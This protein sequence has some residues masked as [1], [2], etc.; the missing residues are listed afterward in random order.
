MAGEIRLRPLELRDVDELVEATGDEPTSFAPGGEEGR[1]RLRRQIERAPT[2][3]D[4]GFF[5]LAVEADG[6][7]CGDVQARSPV[8][9][10]PPGV[11]EIGITLF[12]DARGRGVGREAVRLFT[13]RLFADGVARVQASTAVGNAGMRRVLERLGFVL[14][15]VLR[16]YGPT[17]RG[18]EDYAMYAV[19]REDWE[20]S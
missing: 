11:C 13:D 2:L 20:A 1:E 9:A 17:E 18:R 15:G 16:S 8:G 5:A 10:F 6:R 12:P 19:T 3:A 14:E 4:G 7:L